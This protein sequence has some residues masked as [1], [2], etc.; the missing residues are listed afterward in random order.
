MRERL[1]QAR[2]DSG[3][4]VAELAEKFGI[5]KSFYYK[6]EA[7]IRN[8]TITLANEIAL[9]FGKT[10]DELFFDKELDVLSRDR[11]DETSAT[12]ETA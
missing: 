7:G 10:V 1:I 3:L 12:R 4:T 2:K 9:F 8:P 6:I 5:S 11:N